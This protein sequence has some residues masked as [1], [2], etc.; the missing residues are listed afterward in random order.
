MGETLT[1]HF[2]LAWNQFE[3]CAATTFKNLLADQDFADVTLAC[4]GDKQVKAHKVILSSCSPFFRKV[5]LKNPHQHPLLYLKDVKYKDLILIIRFIYLGQIEIGRECL[6]EFLATAKELEVKGLMEA[7]DDPT[8]DGD[9]TDRI[10]GALEP[11]ME[12]TESC[13]EDEREKDRATEVQGADWW[14]EE[15]EYSGHDR[16]LVPKIEEDTIT[17]EFKSGPIFQMLT[18]SKTIDGKFPCGE[19]AYKA[20]SVGNLKRH[21]LSRH[22]G[23][24][25]PCPVCGKDFASKDG[26]KVHHQNKHE[27]VMFRCNLCEHEATTKSNLLRHMHKKHEKNKLSQNTKHRVEVAP[28]FSTEP[29]PASNFYLS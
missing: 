16:S 27:G 3:S 10:T 28:R 4:D 20:T 7:N 26:L 5:L 21:T 1:E 6:P 11:K 25:V 19:C 9:D 13:S 8:K 15:Y 2:N 22:S 23:E 18:P 29:E 12:I 14:E 24:R 17:T